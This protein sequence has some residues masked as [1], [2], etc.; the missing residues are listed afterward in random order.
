[1]NS[2]LPSTYSKQ[3]PRCIIVSVPSLGNLI[4][5]TQFMYS[6][7]DSYGLKKNRVDRD[8]PYQIGYFFPPSRHDEY[9]IL[10]ETITFYE[11]V[12]A[13]EFVAFLREKGCPCQ[14]VIKGTIFR[15]ELISGTLEQMI[16]LFGKEALRY[17]QIGSCEKEVGWFQSHQQKYM[18]SLEQ[19]RRLIAG[20]TPG[21][22]LYTSQDV[23]SAKTAM[24]TPEIPEVLSQLDER[25]EDGEIGDNTVQPGPSGRAGPPL[26]ST[27]YR[28]HWILEDNGVVTG[29]PEGFSLVREVVAG[30][31]VIEISLE[32]MPDLDFKNATGM[33]QKT[34]IGLDPVYVVTVDPLVH[35]MYEPEVVINILREMEMSDEV[36]ETV[37][38]N[39]QGKYLIIN[40]I[41]E[42]LEKAGGLPVTDLAGRIKERAPGVHQPVLELFLDPAIITMVITEMKKRDILAGN[43][44]N[45]R[46]AGK[47]TGRKK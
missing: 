39:L 33:T 2:R 8:L 16:T 5:C 6:L 28:V 15:E 34:Q 24:F 9:M 7:I 31:I 18:D 13:S 30:D 42:E 25:A 38:E 47:K 23:E 19:I 45:V 21:D 26:D 35:F 40:A 3:I 44:S 27:L 11:E 37:V 46:L 10:G 4:S 29:T 43:D 1:M 12:D 22:I 20:R 36:F 14:Q 32:F 41:M 17:D